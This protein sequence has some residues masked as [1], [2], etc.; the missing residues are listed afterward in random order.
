MYHLAGENCRKNGVPFCG[1]RGRVRKVVLKCLLE[2]S[3]EMIKGSWFISL[4]FGGCSRTG[5]QIQE[6]SAGR[7][8]RVSDGAVHRAPLLGEA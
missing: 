6:S 5:I 4:G 1:C 2:G 8:A 7:A 3:M